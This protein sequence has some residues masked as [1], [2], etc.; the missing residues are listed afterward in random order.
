MKA[1]TKREEYYERELRELNKLLSVKKKFY[2]GQSTIF[3][4]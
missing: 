1:L 2:P 4:K 3:T